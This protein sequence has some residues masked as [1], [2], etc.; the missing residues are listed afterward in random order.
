[1]ELLTIDSIVSGIGLLLVGIV[2]WGL[3]I[4]SA[5]IFLWALWKKSSKAYLWSGL[6]FLIPAIVLSTQ[7]GSFLL[8]LLLPV[9]AFVLA[10][11]TRKKV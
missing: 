3:I 1:M 6:S 4:A 11:F 9:L 7:G 2:L 5:L 8:F 10:Y